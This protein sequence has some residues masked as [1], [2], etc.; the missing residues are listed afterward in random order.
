MPLYSRSSLETTPPP[1]GW[2]SGA[3]RDWGCCDIVWWMGGGEGKVEG[4]GRG[5]VV[6]LFKATQVGSRAVSWAT[7]RLGGWCPATER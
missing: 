3:T 7:G 5:D 4:G 6:T 1:A 2:T